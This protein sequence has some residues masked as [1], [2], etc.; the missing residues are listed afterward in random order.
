M[1][2]LRN[3]G[4][5]IIIGLVIGIVSFVRTLI[6]IMPHLNDRQA[7]NQAIL[8]MMTPTTVLFTIAVGILVAIFTFTGFIDLGKR[9]NNKLL[10]IVSLLTMLLLIANNLISNIPYLLSSQISIKTSAIISTLFL[11]SFS[12]LLFLLGIATLQ[13]KKVQLSKALGIL[14]IIT[15]ITFITFV[16]SPIGLIT[17][18]ASLI[19]AAIMFFKASRQ[20]EK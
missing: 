17:F 14:Y 8:N 15:G 13:L 1:K 3:A 11:I 4:I 20:F 7:V 5:A 10:I 6:K 2:K 12:I 19:V 16:L 18:L 9:F